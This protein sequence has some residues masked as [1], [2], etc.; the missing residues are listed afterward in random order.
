MLQS[1]PFM[2]YECI[3]NIHEIIKDSVDDYIWHGRI[4]RINWLGGNFHFRGAILSPPI[5]VIMYSL[6]K[7]F[8]Y[9][10][11]KAEDA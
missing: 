3:R 4:K 1:I 7:I 10:C 11:V 2:V 5:N 9:K 6:L 8:G